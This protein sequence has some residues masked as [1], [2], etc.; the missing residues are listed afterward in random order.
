MKKI[1][2]YY[3]EVYKYT[4]KATEKSIANGD[5]GK[6]YVGQTGNAKKRQGNWDSIDPRYA[7]PKINKAREIYPPEDWER[8]VLFSS[9][10][11]KKSTRKKKI[12]AMETEMIRKYDSINN[13]FNISEG[14]GMKG[15]HHTEE[16]KRKMSLT[17]MG[18]P[19]SDETKE[20][21]SKGVRK[22]WRKMRRTMQKA[23]SGKSKSPVNGQD[24]ERFCQD[25]RQLYARFGLLD[26]VFPPAHHLD[27][28]P[29]MLNSRPSKSYN[30]LIINIL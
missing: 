30:Y 21:I 16:A 7:G 9:F 17:K 20:R 12:D 26:G 4:L 28:T 29:I 22:Y 23:V 19:V 14:R 11:M 18:H 15:L 2:E 13:G 25:C 24:F 10:Y 3:G 5:A 1:G 6:C 8:E 27:N